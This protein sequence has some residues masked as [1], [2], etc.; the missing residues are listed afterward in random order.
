MRHRLRGTWDPER[1][2]GAWWEPLVRCGVGFWGGR[3]C[4]AERVWATK[5]RS[6]RVVHD[7][8]GHGQV[9]GGLAV[10]NERGNRTKEGR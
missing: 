6:P 9:M 2:V 10:G 7:L 4:G 1:T 5:P 8:G 3:G